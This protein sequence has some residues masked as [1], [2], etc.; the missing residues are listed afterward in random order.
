MAKDFQVLLNRMSPTRRARV[1]RRVQRA[2]A[3]MPLNELRR[4]R[5]LTQEQLAAA[6]DLKQ[7]S[8]SKI[9]RQTDMYVSTL[10]RFIESLGGTLRIT[11]SF[12]GG[13]VVVDQFEKLVGT[14]QA[15]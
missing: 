1:A 4:A 14:D 13:D 9:E 3:K 8:I 12:P 2:M 10:R 6:L 5:G 7:A 15:A 11:A